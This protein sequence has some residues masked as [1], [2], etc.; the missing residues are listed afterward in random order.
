MAKNDV[1]IGIV[2]E[3]GNEFQE[4]IAGVELEAHEFTCP[5][6][7]KSDKFTPEQVSHIVE[8][9]KAAVAYGFEEARK[10]TSED[11]Q[12]GVRGS[13]DLNYRPK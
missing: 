5:A 8:Q 3:C 2:C 10:A 6:C 9:H 12:R 4:G 13:K 1:R 11:L 7:G